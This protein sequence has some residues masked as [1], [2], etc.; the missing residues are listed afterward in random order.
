MCNSKL[1]GTTV[2]ALLVAASGCGK[3]DHASVSAT[4]PVTRTA[5]TA[6]GM[7]AKGT[8]G[9]NGNDS[10]AGDVK[11]ERTDQSRPVK[12]LAQFADANAAKEFVDTRKHLEPKDAQ[13]R[14]QLV[15]LLSFWDDS[16][17][18]SMK[19]SVHV[20]NEAAKIMKKGA[21][22]TAGEQANLLYVVTAKDPNAALLSLEVLLE[23]KKASDFTPETRAALIQDLAFWNG[24]SKTYSHES[25]KVRE[26]AQKGVSR[27]LPLTDAE[28]SAVMD[29]VE[30]KDPFVATLGLEVLKKQKKELTGQT[31]A[32]I[33]ALAKYSNEQ[34]DAYA[35]ESEKVRDLVA[36][37]LK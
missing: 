24:S 1:V 27:L 34:T 31:F 20:R 7:T 17:A 12:D 18:D 35:K 15:Q 2:L 14:D 32:R 29:E 36:S 10:Y 21:P 26:E 22:F 16:S 13:V 5:E 19:T 3:D 8:S 11:A 25:A 6:G 23:E 4:K 9:T 30:Q 37:I 33:K 28:Q